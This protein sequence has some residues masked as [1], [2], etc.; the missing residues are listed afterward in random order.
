MRFWNAWILGSGARE[1]GLRPSIFVDVGSLFSVTQPTLLDFPNGQQAR[2]G[3]GALLYTQTDNTTGTPVT[4]IVNSPTAPDGSANT[5]YILE[6]SYFKEVFLGDTP[7]PR[8]SVGIGVNWNSPF[9]P[10]RIDFA[11][12]L[13]KQPGDDTKTFTFNVGTQF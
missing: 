13:L 3:T 1:M 4:S 2:D 7:S 11:Q 8:L 10:F 5:P 12:I 9:G 6:S